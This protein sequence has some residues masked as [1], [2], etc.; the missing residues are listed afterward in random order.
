MWPGFPVHA[1]YAEWRRSRYTVRQSPN[2]RACPIVKACMRGPMLLV[3]PLVA[4]CL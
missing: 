2:S 1:Y 3:D 4:T